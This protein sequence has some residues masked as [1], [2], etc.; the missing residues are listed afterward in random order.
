MA[1]FVDCTKYT[2]EQ[3]VQDEALKNLAEKDE[4]LTKSL[5]DLSKREIVHDDTLTGG[6]IDAKDPLSVVVSDKE[7]NALKTGKEAGGSGV[8]VKDL[9]PE[10]DAL[11]KALSDTKDRLS[12][13]LTNSIK[14][15][16]NRLNNLKA[17][18]VALA[19]AKADGNYQRIKD[20][21]A[22]LAAAQQAEDLANKNLADAIE[23]LRQQGLTDDQIR[24]IIDDSINKAGG[25]GRYVTGITVNQAT[26][27]VTYTYSDGTRLTG[28]LHDFQGVVVDNKTIGGNGISEAL[29]VKISSKYDNQISI[30]EDG[31]Y[32]G[33]QSDEYTRILYVSTSSGDDNNVG[34]IAR[35]LKTID[36]ALRRQPNDKNCTIY[37][38]AGDTF[39]LT[40]GKN[41]FADLT[42]AI[43]GDDKMS[44]PGEITSERFTWNGLVRSDINKPYLTSTP[45][46]H[47]TTKRTDIPGI[48][49]FNGAI[50]RFE[51]IK[52]DMSQLR[53]NLVHPDALGYWSQSW[54]YGNKAQV[55]LEGCDFD[56]T[57]VDG[58]TYITKYL[59][60]VS[61]GRP[62]GNSLYIRGCRV[63]GAETS[64]GV[65]KDSVGFIFFGLSMTLEVLDRVSPSHVDIATMWGL[66][67]V[68]NTNDTVI[69]LI[70]SSKNNRGLVIIDE[71]Q[72][73]VRNVSSNVEII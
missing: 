31:I 49:P 70:R 14:D 26:G 41:I 27:D 59:S 48:H 7:G 55:V 11:E 6:G 42:I 34:T 65:F 60:S 21:E 19:Q 30:V 73:F 36:E 28:K 52:F 54:I 13:D 3:Q 50:L 64:P 38:K 35:P 40:S 67:S 22:Q 32:V 37:L 18:E 12:G 39:N 63:V 2:K 23:S 71:N 25:T 16:N 9:Q 20:L 10:I 5:D 45:V 57:K 46:Y 17:I 8:F 62:E 33:K 24:Q 4:E 56:F 51:G 69:K 44:A 29:H 61:S 68:D 47:Q 66:Q 15:L 53:S 72:R 1:A 58:T 43:Y